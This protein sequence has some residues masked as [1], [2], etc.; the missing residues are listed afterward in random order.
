MPSRFQ[1]LLQRLR[2]H[3]D[4][5]NWPRL[6]AAGV[7]LAEGA[8]AQ[9]P[10]LLSRGRCRYRFFDT[11]LQAAGR[12]RGRLRASL[13]AW[14]PFDNSDYRI[15]LR[16][17]QAMVWAWDAARV[18]DDLARAG[19]PAQ[20]RLHLEALQRDAHEDGTRLLQGIDGF[21]AQHWRGGVL[22]ASR[23]WPQA[24]DAAAWASWAS[25]VDGAAA[26]PAEAIA[27]QPWLARPWAEGLDLAAL[28]SNT[29]PFERFAVGAALVSLT[30]LSA[31]QLHQAW[32]MQ[33]RLR[34]LEAERQSLA[35]GVAPAIAARDRALALA[36]EADALAA[37]SHA[38]QPLEVLVHLAE[39]LPQ[40]GVLLRDLELQGRNLRLGL[41]LGP[42][43]ARAAL[44]QDLQA[45]GWLTRVTESRDAGGPGRASFEMTLADL[46]PPPAMPMAAAAPA[47]A[48]V[49]YPLPT[50]PATAA[51]PAGPAAL[52]SP[53][54]APPGPAQAALPPAGL[55][56]APATPAPADPGG[57][58]YPLPVA[59]PG[60]RP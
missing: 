25:T 29:S 40:R 13:L 60:A 17:S 49:A 12:L 16:G 39:R 30:G 6:T 57:P 55:P 58:K 56:A 1:R 26:Q 4:L 51:A 21:E 2:P 23:W 3:V 28:D 43:M 27:P 48:T 5:A 34:A 38:V 54:A 59:P 19:A 37:R 8:D 11:E 46:R 7:E 15:V 50:G 10:W 44:V 45:G 42:D 9:G 14:A 31:A 41:E 20:V 36:A 22:R 47:A 33:V 53:G 32:D 52:P 35:A 24:P 18:Q